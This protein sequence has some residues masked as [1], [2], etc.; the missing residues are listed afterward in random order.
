MFK[1]LQ[2]LASTFSFK[3]MIQVSA[4]TM[5]FSYIINVTSLIIVKTSSFSSSS[6]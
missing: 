6:D 1:I 4:M 3:H 2:D 5:S